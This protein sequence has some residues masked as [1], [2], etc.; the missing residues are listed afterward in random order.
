LYLP[1]K[2]K[3]KTKRTFWKIQ[4]PLSFWACCPNDENFN[5]NLNPR[6]KVI[7]FLVIDFGYFKASIMAFVA[8]N[9]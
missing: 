5:L 3:Q 7:K 4:K 8:K 1:K 9:F 2:Q 6:A